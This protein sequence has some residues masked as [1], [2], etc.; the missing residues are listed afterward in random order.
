MVY[1]YFPD[2]PRI[3]NSIGNGTQT[4]GKVDGFTVPRIMYK[5]CIM[6]PSVRVGFGNDQACLNPGEQNIVFSPRVQYVPCTYYAHSPFYSSAVTD[7]TV[8]V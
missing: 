2:T 4:H 6:P 8:T 1:L 7:A 3:W 5:L